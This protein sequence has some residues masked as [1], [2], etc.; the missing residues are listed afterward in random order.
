MII[1][2]KLLGRKVR[3]TQLQGNCAE[4]ILRGV[5]LTPAGGGYNSWEYLF[6]EITLPDGNCSLVFWAINE[7]ELE[8]E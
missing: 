7:C 3:H 8:A 2:P 5:V 6:V 1:D 4:G